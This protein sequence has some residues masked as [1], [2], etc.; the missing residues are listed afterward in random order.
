MINFETVKDEKGEKILLKNFE[1]AVKVSDIVY[2][3]KDYIE[4]PGIVVFAKE[5]KGLIF[6]LI[7][8]G[9]DILYVSQEEF[10]SMVSYLDISEE[11]VVFF[12][13]KTT[14][15]AQV[16]VSLE[17]IKNRL[18]LMKETKD[19]L[20]LNQILFTTN[21]FEFQGSGMFSGRKNVFFVSKEILKSIK[22][23]LL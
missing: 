19:T 23:Y 8:P 1:E 12:S 21:E 7:N 9:I 10:D 16:R 20:L 3:G 11:G 18:I 22:D 14:P 4:I 5:K 15:V 2:F 6:Q 13:T 17:N